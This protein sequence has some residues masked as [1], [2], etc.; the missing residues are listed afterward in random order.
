MNKLLLLAPLAA[1]ACSFPQFE[2][3]KTVETEIP[4]AMVQRLFCKSHNG[5]IVVRAG[6]ASDKVWLRTEMKARGYTQEE[7]DDNLNLLSVAHAIGGEQLDIYGDYPRE[8]FSGWTPTFDF[9]LEVPKRFALRLE[10]HNGGIEAHGIEGPVSILTHNGSIE[11]AV[12]NPKVSATTHNG[13]ITL[14]LGGKALDGDVATH[15]GSIEITFAG[16]TDAR[17]DAET[18]NGSVKV[19]S[20]IQEATVSKRSV[21]GRLG[22][23]SGRLTVVSHNGDIVFR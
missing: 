22:G 4:A 3:T 1:A 21:R 5:S 15:N 8:Q 2:A 11:G 20:G 19:P 6:A 9:T 10:S 17:I 12:D 18:H 14:A 13:G 7:A 16:Q 23:G